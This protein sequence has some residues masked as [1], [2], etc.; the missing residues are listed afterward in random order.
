[1]CSIFALLS[2]LY[3]V[4]Q[5]FTTF[6]KLDAFQQSQAVDCLLTM[7]YVSKTNGKKIVTFSATNASNFIRTK[8]LISAQNHCHCWYQCYI[9]RW[10]TLNKVFIQS[11]T[12]LSYISWHR[13]FFHANINV[14]RW[15]QKKK[16]TTKFPF[17]WWVEERMY[18]IVWFVPDPMVVTAKTS[19][20][21]FR[22]CFWIDLF[23]NKRANIQSYGCVA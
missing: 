21:H 13:L 12:S 4:I 9:F 15:L 11:S 7:K 17:H 19:W 23:N 20:N 8:L 5:A 14:L 22:L 6:K 18:R 3:N 2:R 1:M 16:K 10:V